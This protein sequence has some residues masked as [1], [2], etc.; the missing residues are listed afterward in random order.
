MTARIKRRDGR[1]TE[2][3]LQVISEGKLTA[4]GDVLAIRVPASGSSRRNG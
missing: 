3:Y 4:E 1:K 2:L